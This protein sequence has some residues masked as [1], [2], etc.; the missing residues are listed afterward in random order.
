MS[1]SSEVKEELARQMKSSRHCRLAEAAA[2]LSFAGRI[3]EAEEIPGKA[4]QDKVIESEEAIEPEEEKPKNP[5][6]G[7]CL[8]VRTENLSL[9][10]KYVSLMKQ[11]FGECISLSHNTYEQKGH[12]CVIRISQKEDV[13]RIMQAM[14]WGEG[15]KI[16]HSFGQVTECHPTGRLDGAGQATDGLLIQNICC[17]RA[18]LR[19]AYLTAGSMSNPNKAYHAEIV[20][21][22]FAQAKQLTEIMESFEIFAKIARRK[23]YFIVYLK[24]GSQIIDLL[25]VMEAHKALLQ[26][27]NVRVLKDMRNSVNRQVNCETA[28]INKTV[29]AA[30]TQVE[31]IKLIEEMG[32]FSLL[33]PGLLEM[34]K[35]RLLYPEMP[36]KDL[37]NLLS[38]PV[39]KSGVNHR[40]RKI[41]RIAGELRQED[42]LH[43]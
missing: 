18:F 23:K 25:N 26:L 38:P 24:E 3:E 41:S 21:T 8:I 1:F 6:G 2:I 20:C 17:K 22:T 4:D 5:K 34:A 30:V 13:K 10:K 42:S 40:L 39:G 35:L 32:G 28:N 27:E 15:T 36:L 37:G 19:G 43:R 11:L 14:K 9:A 16:Q 29:N 7:S 33:S 31:D 12:G